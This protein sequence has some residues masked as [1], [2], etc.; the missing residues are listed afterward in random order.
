M[1]LV[2]SCQEKLVNL[3][4]GTRS[5][6]LVTGSVAKSVLEDPFMFYNWLLKS[7]S[8]IEGIV[9]ER[10]KCRVLFLVERVCMTDFFFYIFYE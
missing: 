10:S 7:L 9:K 1:S 3:I 6:F 8:F 5:V 4:Q 2:L